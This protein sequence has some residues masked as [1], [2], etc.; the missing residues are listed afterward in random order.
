MGSIRQLTGVSIAYEARH[1]RRARV[2]ATVG[3]TEHESEDDAGQ[4]VVHRTVDFL[5]TAAELKD[6]EGAIVPTAGD[7]ILSDHEELGAIYE[8]V[9]PAGGDGYDTSDPYGDQLRIHTQRMT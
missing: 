3:R 5:V 2:Q 8:V 1:G 9:G 7:R 4:R 6:E